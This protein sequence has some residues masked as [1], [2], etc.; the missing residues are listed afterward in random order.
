[1]STNVG[2]ISGFDLNLKRISNYDNTDSAVVW[3]E[4]LDSK[5]AFICASNDGCLSAW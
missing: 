3:M 1:M 2:K 5:E 4:K